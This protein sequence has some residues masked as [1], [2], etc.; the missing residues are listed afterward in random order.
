MLK[1]YESIGTSEGTVEVRWAD[2][3]TVSATGEQNYGNPNYIFRKLRIL[4]ETDIEEALFLMGFCS[5]VKAG[6]IVVEDKVAEARTIAD[7][8]AKDADI[9]FLI[10]GTSSELTEDRL[11]KLAYAWG[12]GGMEAMR[13]D[14]NA[15]KNAL[16]DIVL[17]KEKEKDPQFGFDA[18]IEACQSDDTPEFLDCMAIVR[19]A[20][21]TKV[22][23]WNARDFSWSVRGG[24]KEE[25][26]LL[27]QINPAYST[28]RREMLAQAIM[29]DARK[30]AMLDVDKP[31][32]PGAN[33]TGAYENYSLNDW[34]HA[35]PED[36][37]AAK[38][39]AGITDKTPDGIAMGRLVKFFAKEKQKE[40]TL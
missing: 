33:K 28:K 3:N 30:K 14:I 22:I 8:R 5:M 7:R 18:F 32:T 20:E 36:Y 23:K 13:G 27:L 26:V 29:S 15:I 35:A 24:V 12:V 40:E 2:T 1:R 10:Y 4:N 17:L 6:R 37:A 38:K 21:D 11:I 9:N 34:K 19:K 31:L 16:Y 39:L 25:D